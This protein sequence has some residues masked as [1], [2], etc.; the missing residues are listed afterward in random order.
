MSFQDKRTWGPTPRYPAVKNYILP[1]EHHAMMCVAGP[2]SIESFEQMRLVLDNLKES[3]V[4]VS[5]VRGGP[6][7]FGT[8][9]PAEPGLRGGD[10][11]MFADAVHARGMRA[12]VEVLDLRLVE[13]IAEKVDAIQVGARQAQN[14]PLLIEAGRIGKA[15]GIP[16]F[17]KRGVG[18]TVDELL[19]AGE[20]ILRQGAKLVLIERGSATY[21]NHIRWGVDISVIAYIASRLAVPILV[22]ASHGTGRRD[23]VAP[24]TLAG[25]AA[26]AAGFVVET[27]PW[28]EASRSDADQAFP[29]GAFKDLARAANAVYQTRQMVAFDL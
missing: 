9:P 10:L 28:P 25:L 11:T 15:R 5:Y 7:S 2:C 13:S 12:V 3:P 20:Y 4:P 24:V 18:M 6:W 16:V 1:K 26:G 23:L 27:H 8:Y 17:L 14:Y 29:L 21:H 22:D 19:G